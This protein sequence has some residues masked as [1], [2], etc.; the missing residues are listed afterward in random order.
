MDKFEVV[1][2]KVEGKK[3]TTEFEAMIG[4]AMIEEVVIGKVVIQV[5]VI[6]RED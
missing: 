6:E 1:M 4:K 2:G 5:V 3:K